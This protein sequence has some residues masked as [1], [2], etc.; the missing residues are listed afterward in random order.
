VRNA[1]WNELCRQWISKAGA[2]LLTYYDEDAQGF[3]TAKGKFMI[4]LKEENK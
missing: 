1:T 4:T 3:R 2:D